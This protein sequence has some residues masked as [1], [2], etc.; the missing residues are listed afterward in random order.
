MSVATHC[1]VCGR[2]AEGSAGVHDGAGRVVCTTCFEHARA[3]LGKRRAREHRQRADQE[4]AARL[5]QAEQDNTLVTE[6]SGP[7]TPLTLCP[8][9]GR[10]S[11][12]LDAPCM[13]CG[14]YLRA[15]GRSSLR[16]FQG[17][18]ALSHG[19]PHAREVYAWAPKILAVVLVL[20]FAAGHWWYGARSSTD[21]IFWCVLAAVEIGVLLLAGRDSPWRL[22]TQCI[23][24]SAILVLALAAQFRD[25]DWWPWALG[26]CVVLALAV[27]GSFLRSRVSDRLLRRAWTVLVLAGLLET[28]HRIA[29]QPAWSR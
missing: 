27:Q 17:G 8:S 6:L 16:A 25:A 22:T 12:V 9:C 20:G 1:V 21:M 11:P 29:L 24:I 4:K 18:L 15:G 7:Q 28:A 3:M 2:K 19:W 5:A 14:F 23:P 26:A 10:A 13:H